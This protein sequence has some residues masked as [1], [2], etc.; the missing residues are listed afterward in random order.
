VGSKS[1]LQ[2]EWDAQERRGALKDLAGV[3]VAAGLCFLLWGIFFSGPKT[4]AKID[5]HNV[6]GAAKHQAQAWLK[7]GN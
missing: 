5:Q 6:N 2:R 4:P 7:G 1:Q 3:L